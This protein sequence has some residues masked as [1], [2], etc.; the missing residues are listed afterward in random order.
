[1]P[2]P[3]CYLCGSSGVLLY[4]ELEDHLFGVKGQW[5]MLRCSNPDCGL[6]W[7]DPMPEAEEI[8]KLYENYFTHQ[9]REGERLFAQGLRQ[10]LA[11][12][13]ICHAFHYQSARQKP[14][15]QLLAVVLSQ[16]RFFR[17]RAA[18]SILW[19][20]EKGLPGCLLDVGC[21]NG[22]FLVNMRDLGWE[23]VGI[24]QDPVAADIGRQKNGLTIHTGEV[25]GLG[26]MKNSFDVVT[27]SHVMEHLVDPL[28]T[29]IALHRLLKPG[30]KIVMATPNSSSLGHRW[31]RESWRGLEPP[32]HL[33]IFASSSLAALLR[34]AGF[35]NETCTTSAEGSRAIWAQSSLIKNPDRF[36]GDHP[37]YSCGK[38]FQLSGVLL[39]VFE[40][41]AT[42]WPLKKPWGEE[43]IVTAVKSE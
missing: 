1:M 43:L 25:E 8:G 3:D 28:Q 24:E 39:E 7:L 2:C 19:L 38:H 41:L 34:N 21:G 12:G 36:Q 42:G 22:E 30:G 10:R 14:L 35:K 37:H 11:H 18:R 15:C 31:F 17:N 5:S 16:F 32:R 27:M 29:L 40:H 33:H 4:E 13:V 20:D 23:V 9:E 26:L 6:L